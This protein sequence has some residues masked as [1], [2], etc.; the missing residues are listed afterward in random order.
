M[1]DY[2]ASSLTQVLSSNS[3]KSSKSKRDLQKWLVNFG[4]WLSAKGV[5][6]HFS[7]FSVNLMLLLITIACMLSG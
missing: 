3:T 6:I 2:L 1:M 4:T 7:V 5:F